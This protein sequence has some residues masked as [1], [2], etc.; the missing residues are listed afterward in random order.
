M[1]MKRWHRAALRSA[2]FSTT[3]PLQK[4]L[5]HHPRPVFSFEA[6]TVLQLMLAGCSLCCR[7][8]I[9]AVRLCFGRLCLPSRAAL[10]SERLVESVGA[11]C[12]RH[13]KSAASHAEKY[14]GGSKST[15]LQVFRIR[16]EKWKNNPKILFRKY[17]GFEPERIVRFGKTSS[18][19]LCVVFFRRKWWV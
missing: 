19:G 16:G 14:L 7:C 5:V 2:L 13:P 12:A 10:P 17:F 15:I 3:S 6:P 9:C 1:W 8:L 4:V 18:L 11:R